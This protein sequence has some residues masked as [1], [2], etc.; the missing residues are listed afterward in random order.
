MRKSFLLFL[1]VTPLFFSSC[2]KEMGKA[3]WDTELLAPLVD[4]SLNINNILPDSYLQAN[5]DSSL[6]IVFNSD[7]YKIN[8]DTLFNI[9]DTT[10]HNGYAVGGPVSLFPGF[11]IPFPPSASTTY[12]IPGIEL[13]KVIVKSGFVTFHVK[14]KIQEATTYVYSIPCATIAGVP[15]SINVNVPARVGSTP[16]VYNQTF[17]LS[18]YTINLTGPTGTLIN[19]IYT[20]LSANIS[21]AATSSVTVTPSDSL[22]IDNTFFDIIPYYA[23]GYF[24]NNTYNVGP[25]ESGFTLFDRIVDGTIQ[26]EDVNFNFKI[27][28]PIG[29][30]ARLHVNNISSINTHTGT[31]INLVNS[32]IGSPININRAS[33]SGGT[34]FPTYASFPLNTTNSNIKQMIENL[35]NKFSYSMQMVTDPLGNISGSNDFIYSEKLLKASLDME[36]PLSLVANNLTLADTLALNVSP[37]NGTQS[38]HDGTITLFANNGFPFN[39]KLQLY[40]L[41]DNNVAVD[42]IFGYANTIVEAPVNSSLRVISKKMTKITIPVSES[43]M[44]QLYHTKKAVLKVKFNTIDQP[45]YIK[46]YSEYSIDV[47]LVGDFNYT[48]QLQ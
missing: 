16:G 15:F 23:K 43:K 36:I 32:L 8:I 31:A 3:S 22:I 30:D 41:D 35:P 18:G 21:S 11:A 47:K 37:S 40:L 45:Q 4:A 7:L 13:R 20:S 34:V 29:M 10:I 39:A 48:I 24:G 46:I 44:D 26:L 6:K 5:A 42:S 14:S 27:E 33:E 28:N 2:R 17:D 38:I 9:G 25:S 12:S 1:L 19:T